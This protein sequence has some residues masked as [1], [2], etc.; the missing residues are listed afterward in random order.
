MNNINE[1]HNILS[2]RQEAVDICSRRIEVLNILKE[3]LE[4]A[5]VQQIQTSGNTNSRHRGR[6]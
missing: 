1:S 3:L 6:P 2:C 4:H 5:L